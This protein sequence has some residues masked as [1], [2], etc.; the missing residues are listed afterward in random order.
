[1]ASVVNR[2]SVAIGPGSPA[3]EAALELMPIVKE[4][5]SRYLLGMTPSGAYAKGTAIS[6]CTDIDL[7]VS[8]K[9]IPGMEMR[10]VFWSL[11]EFLVG[12]NF[13]PE[14]HS[15]AMRVRHKNVKLDLIPACIVDGNLHEHM[16]FHKDSAPEIR[17]NVTQ[18]VHL[19]SSS[20]R[21]PEIR[22]LKIWVERNGLDFP[23]I[24]LELTVLEA[25]AENRFGQLADNLLT[26]LRYIA[27]RFQ[28]VTVCDPANKDNTISDTLTATE[29]HILAQAA[30]KAVSD[31]DWGQILW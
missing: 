24:Y 17:T 26:I 16:L 1:V 6:L 13:R 23:S 10:D 2:F 25:L 15:V 28:R 21:A 22:A 30:S 9:P 8:L 7:L 31:V 29:K 11:F 19:V 18:H 3:H 14:A 27:R 12:R 5:G 4:W 20:G